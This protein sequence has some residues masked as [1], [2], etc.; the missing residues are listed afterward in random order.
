VDPL[1]NKYPY[2]TPYAYV[3]NNPLKFV[4]PDGKR[5][6]LVGTIEQQQI[7]L[8]GLQ[9]LTNDQLG[10]ARNGIVFIVKYAGA[11]TNKTLSYGTTLIRVL[12]GKG[13]DAKTTKIEITTGGNQTTAESEKVLK[14]GNGS[15][16]PGDNAKVQWNPT[17]TE[18]GTDVNGSD[19]RPPEIG[20]G[21]ELIHSKHYNKGLTDAKSSGKFDPDGSGNIL[22]KEEM[23][24]R[25]DENKIRQEQ[26]L[27][28]RKV[29]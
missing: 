21:H 23:N 14:K 15:N 16:G 28:N 20:L 25:N 1:S 4:D 17:K 19:V 8:Q 22:T 18:G 13:P 24:T 26:G 29:E 12:N 7:E 2:L 6:V 11:N 3:A 27:P 5:I 9:K 10:V